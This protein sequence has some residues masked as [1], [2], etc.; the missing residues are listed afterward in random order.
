METLVNAE[1]V[2]WVAGLTAA[3]VEV[4]KKVAKADLSRLGPV[5]ALVVAVVLTIAANLVGVTVPD[6]ANWFAWTGL[7]GFVSALVSM[8]AYDLAKRAFSKPA[9]E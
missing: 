2:L 3:A 9:E 4:G 1:L 5:I 7:H 6:G 8:G